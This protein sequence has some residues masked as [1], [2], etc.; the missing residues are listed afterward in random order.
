MVRKS[1]SGHL[2]SV[3]FGPSV[4]LPSVF[5]LS[6]WSP[7][8]L[9]RLCVCLTLVVGVASVSIAAGDGSWGRAF[10]VRALPPLFRPLPASEA[11]A[12]TKGVSGRFLSPSVLVNFSLWSVFQVDLDWFLDPPRFC[13]S[14]RR[15]RKPRR[16]RKLRSSVRRQIFQPFGAPPFCLSVRLILRLPVNVSRSVVYFAFVIGLASVGNS[17]SNGR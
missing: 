11:A 12:V 6:H 17:V 14:S 16:K 13:T 10:G 8:H 7:V 5:W 9:S 15:P 2:A 3:F 4:L 1:A